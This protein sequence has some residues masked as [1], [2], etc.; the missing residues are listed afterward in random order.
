MAAKPDVAFIGL[1]AMGFGMA[2]HL[3]KQGYA[4]T[5]FDVWQPTL[6][7]F[8]AAGGQT[9]TTPAAAVAGKSVCVCM[10]AT[11]QQAQQVL[12]EGDAAAAAALPQNAVIL[13]CSTVPCGYVQS[14]AATLAD[15]Q[16]PVRRPDLLLVDCPVSGGAARAADGTLSIMAGAS[17]DALANAA[18]RTVLAD[19]ADPT[20]LY[21]L[22]GGGIGAGSNTKM[23]HQVLAA[24]QILSGPEAMGLAVRLGLPANTATLEALLQSPGRS[25]MFGHRG[26]RMVDGFQP[27]ASAVNIIVKDTAI[28]T[29]EARRAAFPTHMTSVVENVLYTAVNRGFGGKD[30]SQLLELYTDGVPPP[31]AN[32]ASPDAS[33]RL[34]TNLLKGI[35]LVS[36][37]ES[38][39]F[40]HHVGLDLDLVLDLCINAAG[41]SAML[42]THGPGIVAVLR[43]EPAPPPKGDASA[44]TESLGDIYNNLAK[45]VDAAQAI[46]APIHL[47]T[48]ALNLLRLALRKSGSESVPAAA[49]VNVWLR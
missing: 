2:T 33:L 45:A 49:A 46:K 38:L 11:A 15:P 47:G 5:G 16:G 3:V 31:T 29:S 25:W 39:A 21:Y 7:K 28:I 12:V 41:G 17:P 35:H 32:A 9:A 36:A 44:A 6:D 13:L 18:G 40:A 14:L 1:G 26:P 48:Q 8:A 27:L 20:R 30:D 37:A 19:L 10:V 23:V 42:E 4:V 24:N 34:V 43:N 22:V